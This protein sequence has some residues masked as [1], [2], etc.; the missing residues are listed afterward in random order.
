MDPDEHVVTHALTRKLQS[1]S[2]GVLNAAMIQIVENA[3][4]DRKNS[5]TG[6]TD[7][8]WVLARALKFDRLP[9]VIV[10]SAY[11]RH[12]PQVRIHALG[13]KKFYCSVVAYQWRIKKFLHP[14][15]KK[16]STK[17][18][19]WWDEHYPLDYE[20]SHLYDGRTRDFNPFNLTLE[21]HDLNKSRAFCRLWYEKQ[22]REGV[23]AAAAKDAA[24]KTC[25]L[26]HQIPCMYAGAI[27]VNAAAPAAAAASAA[28]DTDNK[29]PAKRART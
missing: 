4:A 1:A 15:E 27:G 19:Q 17:T 28:D 2:L 18:E 11:A 14:D 6:L 12:R 10:E 22:I 20:V 23:P 29:R 24:A 5:N 8:Q 13:K 3:Y 7:T 21:A 25:A 26:L 16:W 9:R